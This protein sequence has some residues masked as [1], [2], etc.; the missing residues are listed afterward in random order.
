VSVGVEV[1]DQAGQVTLARAKGCHAVSGSR[2][3]QPGGL[4]GSGPGRTQERWRGGVS[5]GHQA[6]GSRGGSD[7][8]E[9][10]WLIPQKRGQ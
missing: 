9:R 2:C 3:L 7:R 10:P 8:A 1:Q 4:P 6:P 5:V